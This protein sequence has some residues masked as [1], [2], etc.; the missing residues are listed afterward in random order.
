MLPDPL[1]FF[2]LLALI[3]W[4]LLPLLLMLL[5]VPLKLSE[6]FQIE[7]REPMSDTQ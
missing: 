2:R 4:L 6:A 7:R 3:G 5:T 1:L